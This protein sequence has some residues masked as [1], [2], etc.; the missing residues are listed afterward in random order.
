[1]NCS[2]RSTCL[3]HELPRIAARTKVVCLLSKSA[4]VGAEGHLASITNYSRSQSKNQ[5]RLLPIKNCNSW[6]RMASCLYHKLQQEPKF[7]LPCDMK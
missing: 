5:G 1:M 6:S 7:A 2:S 3:Y 4:T